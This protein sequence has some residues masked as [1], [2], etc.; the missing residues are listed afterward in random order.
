[1][2]YPKSQIKTGLTSNGNLAFKAT[3]KPYYGKY[4]STSDGKYFSGLNPSNSTVELILLSK[5]TTPPTFEPFDMDK[6]GL[7]LRFGTRSNYK[8]STVIGLPDSSPNPLSPVSNF[9]KPTEEDYKVGEFQ[10]YFCKKTN[11]LFYLEISKNTFQQLT[12]NDPNIAFNLYNPISTPW[13]LTGTP[14]SVF[15]T[16]KKI[17]SLIERN[18][19]WYGFTSYFQDRFSEYYL[20]K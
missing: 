13:S 17:I 12:N 6:E 14:Q 10:R 4:F 19:K 3:N 11:E 2:Y 5:S 16:N 8:Y 7:D 9:P 18:Q 20:E 15:N 1:M